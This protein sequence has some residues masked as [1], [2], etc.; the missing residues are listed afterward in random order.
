MAEN[1]GVTKVCVPWK[2][3]GKQTSFEFEIDLLSRQGY[4]FYT[5]LLSRGWDDAAGYKNKGEEKS[6]GKGEIK[7]RKK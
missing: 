7:R 1:S 6:K 2:N 4:I 3:E 5:I